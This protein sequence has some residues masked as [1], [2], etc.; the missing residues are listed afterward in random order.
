MGIFYSK[1]KID[2]LLDTLYSYEPELVLNLII[3]PMF[4][5]LKKKIKSKLKDKRDVFL[6]LDDSN[7]IQFLMYKKMTKKELQK[8]LPISYISK[9]P[10][11]CY[12][13]LS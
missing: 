10:L 6:Y 8:A 1:N 9:E 3:N 11:N 5:D 7:N 2:L 13:I 12:L 4:N